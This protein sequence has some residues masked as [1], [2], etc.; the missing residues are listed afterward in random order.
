[1]TGTIDIIAGESVAGR[2]MRMNLKH[3]AGISAHVSTPG[4]RRGFDRS[5]AHKGRFAASAQPPKE[6]ER[7]IRRSILNERRA[8]RRE[9]ITARIRDK[10]KVKV[11]DDRL[12]PTRGTA[13]R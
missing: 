4:R 2:R 12:A 5:T 8:A 3:I 7:E 6:V 10:L 11:F 1:V 13:S 9:E